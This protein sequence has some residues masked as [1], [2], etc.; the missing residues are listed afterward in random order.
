MNYKTV[1]AYY[2]QTAKSFKQYFVSDIMY[3]KI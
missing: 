2:A 3:T 1:S